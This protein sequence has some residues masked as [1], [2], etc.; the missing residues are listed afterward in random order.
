[1]SAAAERIE[2]L[3]RLVGIARLALAGAA[4]A[5]KALRRE[6]DLPPRDEIGRFMVAAGLGR[7][8]DRK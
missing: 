4:E 8:E 2:E 6:R 7:D 1:M 5:L 3:E